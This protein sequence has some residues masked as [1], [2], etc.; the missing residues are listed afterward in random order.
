M[1]NGWTRQTFLQEFD[2]EAAPFNKAT[3][4]VERMNISK[5]IY[6]DVVEPSKKNPRAY[7]NCADHSRTTRE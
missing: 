7:A 2:F 5:N 4:I 6:E 1:P 3:N